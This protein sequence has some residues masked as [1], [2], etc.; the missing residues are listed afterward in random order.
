MTNK[1][2]FFQELVQKCIDNDQMAQKQLYD[3]FSAK[4]FSICL[5]YTNDKSQAEDVFQDAFM[6]VYK[7]LHT[8]KNI[9]LLAGWIKKVFVYTALNN[10]NKQLSKVTFDSEINHVKND[11]EFANS[12]NVLEN[13]AYDELMTLINTL[14][15]KSKIVFN[16]YIIEGFTHAEIAKMVGISIGTSKSQ[17][18]DARQNLIKKIAYQNRTLLK[19]VV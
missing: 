3:L 15:E 4:M 1:H 9:S 8:V 2:D 16:L 10:N 14:P 11:N 6:K 19:V 12:E 7:N 18:F 13:M 17:L 5:R